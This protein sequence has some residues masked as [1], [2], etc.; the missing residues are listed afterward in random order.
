MEG[1]ELRP[2]SKAKFLGSA[3]S[4]ETLSVTITLRRRHDGP[5]LPDMNS[6]A[7][8]LS[9]RPHMTN[10]EFE[11]KYGA[12]PDDI[13][14]VVE[15]AKAKGLKVV[16]S[17]AA[18][19]TVIVSGTVAQMNEAFGVTLG[20]YQH[21]IVHHRGVTKTET[22]RGREGFVHV[23]TGLSEIILGVF[24]LD[25]RTISKRNGADQP[26][27]NPLT[28]PQVSK[29]YNY[30]TNSAAGQTIGIASPGGGYSGYLQDDLQ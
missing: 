23:P 19:R 16:G 20:C 5:P 26:N 10:D 2:S 7:S 4:N 6:F 28:V 8:P 1:S 24:G 11:A 18:R 21:D 15:F 29:L 9:E 22:Y 13:K 12:A 30:P 27:T 3:D 14:K 17:N 25:N